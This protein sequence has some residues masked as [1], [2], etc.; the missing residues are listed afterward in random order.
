MG[1]RDPLLPDR[2]RATKYTLTELAR[3][4][5]VPLP[6]IKRALSCAT[7]IRLGEGGPTLTE[8][9]C[10]QALKR[11]AKVEALQQQLVEAGLVLDRQPHHRCAAA[12]LPP[13]ATG[14]AQLLGDAP[15]P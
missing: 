7:L 4:L 1:C 14:P 5:A 11:L 2:C 6:R 12:P 15:R 9:E 13:T 10:R 8:F 3:L